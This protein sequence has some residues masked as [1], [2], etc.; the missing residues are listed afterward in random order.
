MGTRTRWV[1]AL[2]GVTFSTASASGRQP[3]PTPVLVELFTSEGCS[4]CPPAD[5]LLIDLIR[6]QPVKGAVV[7]GL[8]EHVD[9]WD[10]QGWKDPFSSAAFTARQSSYASALHVP[11]IYTPQMVVD[12]TREFVGQDRRA[13][14][15][16][17]ARAA[18]SAKAPLHLE[19]AAGDAALSIAAQPSTVSSGGHVLLAITEDNLASSVTR[20]ENEGRRLTHTSVVRRLTDLGRA[21][22]T[23]AFQKTVPVR[24][25]PTWHRERLRA[26]VF[27]QSNRPP[28]QVTAVGA[29]AI[30]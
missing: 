24:L 9:Y 5:Q 7:I 13:A 15:A 1:A 4:S 29:I 27:I 23:G 30:R 3:T 19:W 2:L 6:T 21:E 14:L 12:G 22:P 28:L 11:D 17:V 8:S 20:G 16:A 18:A 10:H 26:V 25:D